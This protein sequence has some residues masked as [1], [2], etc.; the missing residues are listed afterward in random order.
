MILEAIKR[1][2]MTSDWSK[3]YWHKILISIKMKRKYDFVESQKE[4][5]RE[6]NKFCSMTN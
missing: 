2:T 1:D 6:A 5:K 3:N 4:K